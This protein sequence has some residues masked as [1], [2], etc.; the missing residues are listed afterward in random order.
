[1][2]SLDHFEE[3]IGY[4]FQKKALLK[5]ALT[6]SSVRHSGNMFERLEFLGDR[7]LGVVIAQFLYEQFEREPEG[8][9]A[10]RLAVLVSKDTCDKVGHLI[11]LPQV[12][13]LS[14]DRS[15][16][17]AILA[18]AVEALIGAI[19]LDGG[20]DPCRKFIIQNW[21]RFVRESSSPPKD[22]KTTLQEWAQSCGFPVPVYTLVETTGPDH[23]PL[24]RVEV[25][26]QGQPSCS[27]EGNSKRVAEQMAAAKLL[28][29][30]SK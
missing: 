2:K 27:G 16:N 18:D 13:K 29:S 23:A 14:G 21:E 11:A 5:G 6:H 22:A 20:L 28:T 1:M 3:K 9:L 7:V 26:V 30:V 4:Q 15:G 17:S 10:K 19:Y 25:S 8:D 12:L 24:F